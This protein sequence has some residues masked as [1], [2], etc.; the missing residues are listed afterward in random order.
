MIPYENTLAHPTQRR[1]QNHAQHYCA[2]IGAQYALACG[3][4]HCLYTSRRMHGIFGNRER[5]HNDCICTSHPSRLTYNLH[6]RTKI[7]KRYSLRQA[8]KRAANVVEWRRV[9]SLAIIIDRASKAAYCVKM[10]KYFEMVSDNKARNP[11]SGDDVRWHISIIII[12]YVYYIGKSCRSDH[13]VSLLP[14]AN[15]SV[16]CTHVTHSL[17][18]Y[19]SWGIKKCPE[20][21]YYVIIILL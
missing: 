15:Y 10:C 17:M 16:L 7:G 19:A 9:L 13:S 6:L 4:S 12:Y 2:L 14:L 3:H 5:A 21:V 18:H 1:T 20:N 8:P 11:D